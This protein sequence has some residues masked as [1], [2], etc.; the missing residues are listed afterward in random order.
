MEAVDRNGEQRA[1]KRRRRTPD[2][3]DIIMLLVG[4]AESLQRAIEC[5]DVH[6][7]G[8]MFIDQTKV[9]PEE[10]GILAAHYERSPRQ[11]HGKLVSKKRS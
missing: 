11:H 6:S 5:F 10:E 7:S 1:A 8:F 9:G 2:P 3:D 4:Q